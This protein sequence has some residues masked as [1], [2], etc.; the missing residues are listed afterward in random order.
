MQ[1]NVPVWVV[2]MVLMAAVGVWQLVFSVTGVGRPP[3]VGTV[4]P[5]SSPALP[6]IDTSWVDLGLYA[7]RRPVWAP[8]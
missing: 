2:V 5:P 6:Q 3:Q 4:S 7:K 1:A 8:E